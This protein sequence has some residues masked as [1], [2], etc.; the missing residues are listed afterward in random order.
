MVRS[1][2]LLSNQVFAGKPCPVLPVQQAIKRLNRRLILGALR[3]SGP[4]SRAALARAVGLTKSM[5]S[6]LVQEIL[7]EGLLDEGNHHKAGLGRPGTGLEFSLSAPWLW[8]LS[9][10]REYADRS[11]R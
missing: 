1:L 9:W 7:E 10:S 3:R 8:G 4:Q 2:N 11:T 5:V 6:S